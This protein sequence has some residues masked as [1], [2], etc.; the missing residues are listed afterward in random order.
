MSF[1]LVNVA[2]GVVCSH[3]QLTREPHVS[4]CSCP[5]SGDITVK[6]L[7]SYGDGWHGGFLE[8]E[9]QD[10]EA[11][12]P[13]MT[14][15]ADF[16]DGN[17][18]VET[19]P[20]RRGH[21]CDLPAIEAATIKIDTND[22]NEPHDMQEWAGRGTMVLGAIA[23]GMQFA[24]WGA[25]DAWNKASNPVFQAVGVVHGARNVFL[26]LNG[27]ANDGFDKAEGAQIVKEVMGNTIEKVYED[28]NQTTE[29]LFECLGNAESDLMEEL[30]DLNQSMVIHMHELDFTR[31]LDGLYLAIQHRLGMVLEYVVDFQHSGSAWAADFAD[32]G[33]FTCLDIRSLTSQLS[34]ITLGEAIRSL[35]IVNDLFTI[36]RMLSTLGRDLRRFEGVTTPES[37]RHLEWYLGRHFNSFYKTVKA[38]GGISLASKLGEMI[39]PFQ[40]RVLNFAQLSIAHYEH[41]VRK[42]D[43]PHRQGGIAVPL[44]RMSFGGTAYQREYSL[45]SERHFDTTCRFC[46]KDGESR[47]HYGC[48][49]EEAL[50]ADR[51][52]SSGGIFYNASLDVSNVYSCQQRQYNSVVVCGGRPVQ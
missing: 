10:G 49:E 18:Q 44:V 26:G 39:R 51:C 11:S 37:H 7:D 50:S 32:E 4:V 47:E 46:R 33:L 15:C 36:C 6:C 35:P 24:K 31:Q 16:S 29:A 27:L 40:L 13:A 21:S 23:M 25:D 17:S 1:E 2:G 43:F 19:L 8:I 45:G 42:L 38:L 22:K 5:L 48:W 34:G 14:F 12:Y 28:L 30:D 20:E 9:A 52:I 3:Q 41:D